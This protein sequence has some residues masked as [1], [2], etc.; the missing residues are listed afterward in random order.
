MSF[1]F[2]EGRQFFLAKKNKDVMGSFLTAGLAGNLVDLGTYAL[3]VVA[4]GFHI[5]SIFA[6]VGPNPEGSLVI[7][8]RNQEH[9]NSYCPFNLPGTMIVAQAS[10]R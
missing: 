10:Y 7:S 9:L 5:Y 4:L 1:C 8:S 2:N 6:Y 3:L